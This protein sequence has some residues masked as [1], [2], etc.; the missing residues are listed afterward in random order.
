[1]SP[2][3][4]QHIR[5]VLGG[6][7]EFLIMDKILLLACLLLLAGCSTS[8]RNSLYC[9]ITPDKEIYQQ[10][11]PVIITCSILNLSDKEIKVEEPHLTSCAIKYDGG[12]YVYQWRPEA[13]PKILLL[14][15]GEQ[16]IKSGEIE[17]RSVIGTYEIELYGIKDKRIT[18][19]KKIPV[20]VITATD[21]TVHKE[22]VYRLLDKLDKTY[23][24]QSLY[25]SSIDTKLSCWSRAQ[26]DLAEIGNLSLEILRNTLN[27]HQNPVIRG[28]IAVVLGRLKSKESLPEL[29]Q[30]L[31][32][33]HPAVRKA[34]IDALGSIKDTASKE[35]LIAMLKDEDSWV[36]WR[37]I[38]ALEKYPSSEEVKVLFIDIMSTDTDS[39]VRLHVA[40]A[41]A[42]R[43]KF[44]KAVPVLIEFL[45]STKD[46]SASWIIKDLGSVTGLNFGPVPPLYEFCCGDIKE[47]QKELEQTINKWLLWWKEEGKK[48]YSE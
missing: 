7:E 6:G 29:H 13:E 10:S 34:V 18:Y 28:E 14:Q 39:W 24:D 19:P 25:S 23:Y 38:V 1:V 47:A 37:V 5:Y 12:S 31:K 11:E 33:P 27:S 32:D 20:K 8:S 22:K 17:L 40:Q 21:E 3:Y 44:T 42:K 26:E 36:R 16:W 4:G 2:D 9:S 45:K 48:K 35:E 41:L 46:D 43:Y 15:P 30:A